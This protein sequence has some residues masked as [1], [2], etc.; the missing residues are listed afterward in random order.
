M[1]SAMGDE[2]M[3][4]TKRSSRSRRSLLAAFL[5]AGSS[6]PL[7]LG[8]ASAQDIGYPSQTAYP[9]EDRAAVSRDLAAARAIAGEDLETAFNWRCLISPLDRDQVMGVQHDGL[10][11]P[12][13]IFDNLYS[14]GQNAVSA[15]ALDTS[16]GIII[17]DALNNEAEAREIIIPNLITLGLDPARIR[18][19][20]VTHGHGDHWG[21]ARYLQDTLGARVAM[22]AADWNMVESPTH[23]GGPFASLTPPPSR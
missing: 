2:G 15:F 6:S 11:P 17:I 12:V 19:V 9:N 5:L 23:G 18:Y 7:V 4:Q 16:E 1:P 22:S 10:I 13:R 8:E 3:T 14:V 21:G 20:I